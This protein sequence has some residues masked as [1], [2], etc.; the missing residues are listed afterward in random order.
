M[1]KLLVDTTYLLPIF[2]IKIKLENFNRLFPEILKKYNVLYNPISI[3]EA[4]WIILRLIKKYPIKK[5]ALLSTF[6]TG[7]EILQVDNRLSETKLT[8]PKIEE[9]ADKLM[10]IG[11]KDYFDR[12]IYSTAVYQ[13]AIFLTEDVELKELLNKNIPKPI[14]I[15]S[16]KEVINLKQHENP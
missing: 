8:T 9:L 15:I 10:E 7:L 3:V 2:G 6:R 11:I 1:D 14:N 5:E 13:K 4:K 12:I 16:W